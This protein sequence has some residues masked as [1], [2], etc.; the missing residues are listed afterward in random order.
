MA[1]HLSGLAKYT[2]I[3]FANIIAPLVLWQ[4]KK[5][6]HPFIDDQ[7]KEALNFQISMTLYVLVGVALIF[8]FFIGIPLLA[9][10][11][12]LDV[13]LMVIAGLKANAGEVYRYP[14]TIRLIK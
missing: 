9:A 6:S 14:L 3:P 4:L 5:D 8:C 1:C 2:A 12:I 13:V 7:G 10:L 11:G